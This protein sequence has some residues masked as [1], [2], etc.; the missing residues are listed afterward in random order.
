MT[1]TPQLKQF[2]L[3]LIEVRAKLHPDITLQEAEAL[4]SPLLEET[5]NVFCKS[6]PELFPVF[7]L[8]IDNFGNFYTNYINNQQD[9]KSATAGYA[10]RFKEIIAINVEFLFRGTT[11][12]M[13]E[14]EIISQMTK[15]LVSLLGVVI[16][17]HQHYLQ[18]LA[19]GYHF[20]EEEK[21]A[22]QELFPS[23]DFFRQVDW[24]TPGK[25]Q[26]LQLL[27]ARQA[28]DPEIVDDF[29]TEEKENLA[30]LW[31]LNEIWEID[32]R[33]ASIEFMQE[34]ELLFINIQRNLSA[35]A[36][37]MYDEEKRRHFLVLMGT[38]M[39]Q[40][41]DYKTE[42][43][44]FNNR[45]GNLDVIFSLMSAEEVL[46]KILK[47]AR[48]TLVDKYREEYLDGNN[49][50]N[51]YSTN[52]SEERSRHQDY[53]YQAL[54]TLTEIFANI[55]KVSRYDV[56][57]L[58]VQNGL[59]EIAEK[60]GR[61]YNTM[62]GDPRK[63]GYNEKYYEILTGENISIDSLTYVT[64]LDITQVQQLI[65]KFIQEGKF[66][67]VEKIISTVKTNIPSLQEE[68]ED[69]KSPF[70]ADEYKEGSEY[71]K[72]KISFFTT[73]EKA[74]LSAIEHKIK[75]LA[76]KPLS[77][78]SFDDMDEL[79]SLMNFIA[80]SQNFDNLLQSKT[81]P[82]NIE[83]EDIKKFHNLYYSLCNLAFLKAEY[84]GGQKLSPAEFNPANPQHRKMF[85]LNQDQR[86]ERYLSIYG[87]IEFDRKKAQNYA[88]FSIRSA[89]EAVANNQFEIL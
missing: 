12:S 56:Y 17:E 82:L 69:C 22:F 27:N 47:H 14:A 70:G 24:H 51:P 50:D 33:R 57:W 9:F 37:I 44:N 3:H 61:P 66:A 34:L 48:T 30:F 10:S 29:S 7:P 40:A 54:K 65:D 67:F 45:K 41:D 46:P 8:I 89:Q 4:I 60:Y 76:S 53:T 42:E 68:L 5:R 59:I 6:A 78:S 16:H 21:E 80:K 71:L 52:P 43:A 26:V 39:A 19:S 74:T 35:N 15:N 36:D 55:Y 73:I 2:V 38:I 11:K 32:S 86:R 62:L 13:P 23:V 85:L 49:M 75:E 20:T 72:E 88:I 81:L 83:D 64:T 1:P 58:L 28:I 84:I 79:L 18:M 25:E 63:N 31:Y 87:E 77:K